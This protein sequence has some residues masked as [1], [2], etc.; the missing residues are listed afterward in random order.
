MDTFFRSDG[1]GGLELVVSD[2][3]RHRGDVSSKR[4]CTIPGR[5]GTVC[6]RAS[7]AALWARADS[8]HA[9]IRRERATGIGSFP[10]LVIRALPR[11]P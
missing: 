6:E 4:R 1:W 9:L 5:L 7:L 3:C 10:L 2:G 11:F 8:L